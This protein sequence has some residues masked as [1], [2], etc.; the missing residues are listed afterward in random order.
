MKPRLKPLAIATLLLTAGGWG[1]FLGFGR[2]LAVAIAHR[3]EGVLSR[4]AN[5]KF[6]D[7]V[8]FV[9]G[10]LAEGLALA[11]L[12]FVLVAATLWIWTWLGR[13]SSWAPL[14]GLIAGVAVFV[15]L[16]IVAWAAG[17]TVLFW[18]LFYDKT[19]I[20]NFAQYHIKR[21]LMDEVHG[22]RRAILLGS[23]QTNRSIDEVLM[24]QMIGDRIWTTEL[25]QPGARGFDLLT[26]SRDIPL[27]R[28][29][30]VICYL[31]EIMFA[32]SG[33]GIVVASF[34]N[35]SEVPDAFQLGG[36]SHLPGE[37]VRSGLLGRVLPL[38]R[39]R[40][41]LSNRVL[42]WS[43]SHLDQQRFDQSLESDLEAQA[44]R[45]APELRLDEASGFEQMAFSRMA[46]EL[47]DKGCTL[48]VISG[49]TH[50]A[51]RR[52]V[53]PEVIEHLER[54]LTD[55]TKKYPRNVV[56]IHGS[57]F[58][59]PTDSDFADLVHFTD[60]AQRRFSLKL[61]EYLRDF[62]ADDAR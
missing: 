7:P 61:S 57:E 4:V 2:K 62:H 50:P 52:H 10:R 56:L 49:D 19:Q 37:A 44:M 6:D 41:S 42:G 15:F 38:Y 14:R 59:K 8:S 33:N 17:Q 1:V 16:N 35:F 30:I 54:F 21:A 51:M 34:M 20:D 29:D 13:R 22:K 32:G 18:A 31:S 45:R 26:L 40:D 43:I 9:H 24:N 25:T 11:T 23:S 46:G 27:Q 39:Y 3:F 55:L 36:W 48:L 28:G 5:G 60:A 58:F 47:A 53:N 12:V